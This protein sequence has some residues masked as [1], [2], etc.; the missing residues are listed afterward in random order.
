MTLVERLAGATVYD[1]EQTRFA[2]MPTHPAH[3]PAYFYGLYRRHRDNYRPETEG[4]RSSSSGIITMMEH[5]GMHIDALCRQAVD[6]RLFG[7]V[8]VDAVETSAGFQA[9]GRRDD[10]S[11]L[12]ARSPPRRRG[13]EARRAA[14]LVVRRFGRRHGIVRARAERGGEKGRRPPRRP[15]QA[16]WRDR[17]SDPTARPCRDL[18]PEN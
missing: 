11:A 5:S 7:G 8:P 2:G 6:L 1:L 9:A 13:L 17:L 14:A 3:K 18:K 4:S 15:T 10:S 16:S 12:C